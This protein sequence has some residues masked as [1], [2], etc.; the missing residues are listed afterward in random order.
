MV[1]KIFCERFSMTNLGEVQFILGLCMMWDISFKSI[2]LSQSS[3]IA[4][5]L[6]MK[7]LNGCMQSNHYPSRNQC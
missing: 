3:D 4:S 2:T 7:V 1:E 5:L 6:T